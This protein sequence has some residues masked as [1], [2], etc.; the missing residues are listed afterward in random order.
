VRWVETDPDVLGGAFFVMDR[1]EGRVPP[2]VLPYTMEGFVLDLTDGQRR[3]LQD[4]TVDALAE[5]HGV[6]LGEHTAF[7]EYDQP[8]DTA[9][10]RHV[11][12]WRA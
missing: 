4:S 12:H 5:I 6:P 2:D 11:N 3:R 8:G 7:L 10:R 1:V 9:L